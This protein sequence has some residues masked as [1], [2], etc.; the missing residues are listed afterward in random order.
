LS[1]FLSLHLRPCNFR[2]LIYRVFILNIYNGYGIIYQ[3]FPTSRIV[4]VNLRKRSEHVNCLSFS[5]PFPVS[6]PH[7]TIQAIE[8]NTP[9]F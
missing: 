4:S 3:L 6:F 2:C 5:F 8:F 7:T 1:L 9:V